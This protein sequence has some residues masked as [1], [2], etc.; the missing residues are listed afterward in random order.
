VHG[1]QLGVQGRG[2]RELVERAGEILRAALGHAQHQVRFRRFA[3]LQDPVDEETALGGVL[4]LE[5]GEAEHVGQRQVV[6]ARR[7]QRRQ[8]LDDRLRLAHPQVAVGLEV[9]GLDVVG[10]GGAHR[11][12][13]AHRVAVARGLIERDAEIQANLVLLGLDGERGAIGLDGLLVVTHL[14]QHH[15][16]VRSRR[17]VRRLRLQY[18][19]IRGGGA[20]AIAGLLQRDGVRVGIVAGGR[21]AAGRKHRREEHCRSGHASILDRKGP[22]EAGPFTL[23]VVGPRLAARPAPLP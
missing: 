22:A 20:F 10:L 6:L 7:L 8:Q 12:Q 3:A 13:L 15:A 19:A 11:G 14:R 17:D 9:A 21:L 5:I 16:E 4:L 1:R 2:L 18:L 23:L